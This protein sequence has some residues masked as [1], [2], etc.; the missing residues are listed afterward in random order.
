[1][2][3]QVMLSRFCVASTQPTGIAQ[4]TRS[5]P[6]PVRRR[7]PLRGGGGAWAAVCSA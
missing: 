4:S 7:M 3:L 6:G 5:Q 1:M 2:L